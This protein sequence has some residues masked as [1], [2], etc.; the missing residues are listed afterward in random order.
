[1]YDII[2]ID[3]KYLIERYKQEL[4]EFECKVY[5][6]LFP[7]PS[8]RENFEDILYRVESYT[9]PQ[10]II[11]LYCND[12]EI[13]GGA[14]VDIYRNIDFIELIYLAVRIDKQKCG[15]GRQLLEK[16]EEDAIKSGFNWCILEADNPQM[17]SIKDTSMNPQQRIDMY[18]K[19]GYNIIPCQHIQPPLDETKDYD[20]HLLLLCKELSDIKLSKQQLSKFLGEFYKGLGGSVEI[21]QQVINSIK[22]E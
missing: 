11:Y 20:Y 22:I 12:S 7:L 6:P 13:I 9:T 15:I 16:V 14:V 2:K 19:W 3:S 17:T 5:N 21:L 8:E 4:N 1:M 10:T 18:K